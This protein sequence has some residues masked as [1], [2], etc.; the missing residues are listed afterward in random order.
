[1]ADRYCRNCGKELNPDDRF[2]SNCARPVH[3]TAHVPMPEADVPVPPPPQEQGAGPASPPPQQEAT[4]PAQGRSR[5]RTVVL[6][7]L[8]IIGILVV[9]GII[10]AALGGGG[11]NQPSSPLERAEQDEGVEGGGRDPEAKQPLEGEKAK[12]QEEQANENREDVYSMGEDV[13]VGDV[14]YNLTSAEQVTQLKDPYGLEPPM[15]GN[16]IVVSFVFTNNGDEPASVSDIGMYLYDDQGRQFETDTDAAFFLPEDKSLY[17]LDRVN[18]G[19]SKEIQTVYSVP[20][21]AKGFELEVSSGF[22]QTETA[23]I[24]L[25]F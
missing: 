20:P 2:C 12:P 17:L 11:G 24:A 13:K 8:G 22:W 10:G 6:G 21:D 7:C 23:R 16:F 9:L 15:E 19:L 14:A 5:G 1:M 4:A 25:G 18:P 3:E